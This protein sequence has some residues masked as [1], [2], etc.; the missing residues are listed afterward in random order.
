MTERRT[1]ADVERELREHATRIV[2]EA[3]PRGDPPP[4]A[5]EHTARLIAAETLHNQLRPVAVSGMATWGLVFVVMCY[6]TYASFSAVP[7]IALHSP[8]LAAFLYGW[9]I[10]CALVATKAAFACYEKRLW[11]QSLDLESDTK[12][13][14]LPRRV[15][16]AVVCALAAVYGYGAYLT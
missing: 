6:V 14:R 16:Y 11:L 7:K 15:A 3:W 8:A 9:S 12:A 1:A 5:V 2:T 10:V 13:T 4:N